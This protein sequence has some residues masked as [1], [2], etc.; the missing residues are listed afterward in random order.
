[1]NIFEV[2]LQIAPIILRKKIKL[3]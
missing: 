1:M 3:C 2:K